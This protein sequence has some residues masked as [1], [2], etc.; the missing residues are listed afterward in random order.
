MAKRRNSSPNGGKKNTQNTQT[1]QK[2]QSKKSVVGKVSAEIGNNGAVYRPL[3]DA[4]VA[5][6]LRFP[7]SVATFEAMENDIVIATALVASNIIA[8]RT[9]IS[10]EAFDTTATH[11]KR[12]EFVESCFNDMTHTLQDF[13]SYAMTCNQYGFAL[14]EKV[15]RFRNKEH[16]SKFD[17]GKIGIKRLPLR[18]PST[19]TGWDLDDNAREL[20]GFYQDSAKI[21]ITKKN[22]ENAFRTTV[23]QKSLDSLSSSDIY[24][25][26]ENF[27]HIRIGDSTGRPEGKSPLSYCYKT[28]KEIEN[29]V[30]I[31]GLSCQ[32]NM[33]GVPVGKLPMNYMSPD[34][35]PDEKLVYQFYKDG[36]SNLG[37]HQQNCV[38]IP[39]DRDE[40]GSPYFDFSLEASSA[41]NI[42][43][44]SD[45]IKR[46]YDRVYQCLLADIMILGSGT[47]GAVKNK[48]EMLNML[49]EARLD[50]ILDTVNS[51]LIPDLFER[52]GWDKTKTPKMVKGKLSDIDMATFGKAIQQLTAV[53]MIAVTPENV[54]F[55]A[56]VMNLPYR[57]SED[58]T[59]EELTELL[60]R[61]EKIQSRS[62]DGLEKG[63]GNGTSDKVS[64]DDNSAEN[65]NNG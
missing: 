42:T 59:K 14:I 12:R 54:N 2:T 16:G 57:V 63:S 43:A 49:V 55:I 15:Y 58:L 38:I 44:V 8:Q 5:K 26:R 3:T 24:I 41:S 50:L 53:G 13:I 62:G 1:Q 18:H 39:S 46:K 60:G 61:D 47:S 56:S 11:E 32:K 27:L 64:V 31:E 20:K 36:L 48:A 34:A 22:L 45:V 29:L 35:T 23:L 25:P 17:D 40:N 51:D 4:Q 10:F 33:N 6:A 19:V 21:I 30:E 65:L 7:E 9:P 52:N 28:I 37:I